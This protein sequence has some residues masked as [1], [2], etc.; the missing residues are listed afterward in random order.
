M[1][2]CKYVSDSY[3][4]HCAHTLVI[5][6]KSTHLTT[7]YKVGN[8]LEQTVRNRLDTMENFIH[9]TTEVAV[10]QV[11]KYSTPQTERTGTVPVPIADAQ[12]RRYTSVTLQ[13]PR[14]KSTLRRVYTDQLAQDEGCNGVQGTV[15][16]VYGCSLLS[17]VTI[18]YSKLNAVYVC[19]E[20][21]K[22]NCRRYINALLNKIKNQFLTISN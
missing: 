14:S 16:T 9:K 6:Q 22:R 2:F 20:T 11:R 21:T 17:V 4:A 8:V 5:I 1:C 7:V 19:N 3:F 18:V 10:S 13:M 15:H 12:V